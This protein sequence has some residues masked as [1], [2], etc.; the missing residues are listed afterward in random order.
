M[1]ALSL[2]PAFHTQTVKCTEIRVMKSVN[3]QGFLQK[4]KGVLI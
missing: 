4:K 3:F 2:H 1:S